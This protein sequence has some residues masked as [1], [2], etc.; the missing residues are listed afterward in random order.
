MLNLKAYVLGG[1]AGS[2]V[3]A[4]CIVSAGNGSVNVLSEIDREDG[5]TALVNAIL[6]ARADKFSTQNAS[7]RKSWILRQWADFTTW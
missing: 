3:L 4:V 1:L 5:T 2:I 6:V 7:V